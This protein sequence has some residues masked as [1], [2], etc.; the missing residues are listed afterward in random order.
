VKRSQNP[1]IPADSSLP[2]ESKEFTFSSTTEVGRVAEYLMR[3][4]D[5]L[6]LGRVSLSAPG[7]MVRLELARVVRLELGAQ[8]KPE[9]GKASLELDISWEPVRS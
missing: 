5:G 4:A 8:S 7:R 3:I 2:G 9:E 6:R 1:S